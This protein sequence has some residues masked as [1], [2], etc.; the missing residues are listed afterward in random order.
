MTENGKTHVFDYCRNVKVLSHILDHDT[1]L[2][3]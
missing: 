1:N 2:S 3:N